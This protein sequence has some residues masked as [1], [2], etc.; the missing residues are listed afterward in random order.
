MST[1]VAQ[2]YG[3]LAGPYRVMLW[4][5]LSRFKTR[6]VGNLANELSRLPHQAR[7]EVIKRVCVSHRQFQT[8]FSEV[9]QQYQNKLEESIVDLR[10]H[11]LINIQGA[12]AR[13]LADCRVRQIDAYLRSMCENWAKLETHTIEHASDVSNHGADESEIYRNRVF[14]AISETIWPYYGVVYEIN[15]QKNRHNFATWVQKSELIAEPFLSRIGDSSDELRR[16]VLYSAVNLADGLNG[17]CDHLLP[18]L[19]E[20]LDSASDAFIDFDEP[21]KRKLDPVGLVQGLKDEF[22][23][24]KKLVPIE[25][26]RLHGERKEVGRFVDLLFFNYWIIRHGIRLS[27]FDA[28]KRIEDPTPAGV[29]FLGM[30]SIYAFCHLVP[31]YKPLADSEI[32]PSQ[33]EICSSKESSLRERMLLAWKEAGGQAFSRAFREDTIKLRTKLLADADASARARQGAAWA[34]DVKNWTGPIIDDLAVVFAETQNL[35]VSSALE[36]ALKRANLNARL[37]NIVSIGRQYAF[38]ELADHAERRTT[39]LVFLDCLKGV[40]RTNIPFIIESAFQL[41]L[42]LH[43]GTNRARFSLHWHPQWEESRIFDQT[44]KFLEDEDRATVF[45][46]AIAFL[47]EIAHNMKIDNSKRIPGHHKINVHYRIEECAG[48]IILHVSQRHIQ[49]GR[50]E[51]TMP[52]GL[53]K[54]NRLYGWDGA[55]LGQIQSNPLLKNTP[56]SIGG[57]EAYDITYELGVEFFLENK[58]AGHVLEKPEPA[59]VVR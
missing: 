55:R 38:A 10:R 52:L 49:K 16:A 12:N 20:L 41:L 59:S 44:E 31:P 2:Q 22:L 18:K 32:I 33:S 21:E 27:D 28:D 9:R 4:A 37:L 1:I 51:R 23:E 47:R 30:P 48:K 53:E 25:W 43:S 19:A 57:I 26:G 11:K 7:Y 35:A 50:R 29:L 14:A 3:L 40:A 54:A 34:H 42:L 5:M 36:M 8:T 46:S 45:S 15:A 6:F 39:H 56:V 13:E 24:A 58:E 17:E